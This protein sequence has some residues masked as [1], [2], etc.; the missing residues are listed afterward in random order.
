M[1]I[2][3]SVAFIYP[4]EVSCITRKSE[5][6][7]RWY[8]NKVRK[9]LGKKIRQPITVL[10]FCDFTGMNVENVVDFLRSK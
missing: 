3:P 4:K 10:E 2:D 8:L 6:H 7:A 5:S 9:R 1:A